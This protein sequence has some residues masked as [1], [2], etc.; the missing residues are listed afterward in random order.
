MENLHLKNLIQ[1]PHPL[2]ILQKLNDPDYCKSK[3][4]PKELIKDIDVYINS[5]T[6]KNKEIKKFIIHY[7]GDFTHNHIK[8]NLD[9]TKKIITLLSKYKLNELDVDNYF[10]FEKINREI[11]EIE[12]FKT[13]P[14]NIITI[15][16]K[17]NYKAKF[18]LGI[19]CS[20]K[21]QNKISKIYHYKS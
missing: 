17:T 8:W 5:L 15:E 19:Y 13:I 20:K 6:F 10:D 21:G 4:I 12:S 1:K 3:Y 2:I 14:T 16:Y 7:L 9:I 18:V 11:H